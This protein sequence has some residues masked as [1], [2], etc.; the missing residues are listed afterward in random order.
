MKNQQL[1]Q[2]KPL[3]NNTLGSKH[4]M[5]LDNE[6]VVIGKIGATYGIKGWL[7]IVSFT[8]SI[9]NIINYNPWYIEEHKSWQPLKMNEARPH[10]KGII[11][12]I[13][14]FDTPEQARLLTGKQI[15]IKRSQL[16]PL[17]QHEYYWAEL[18]GLTVINQHNET[19]GKIIYL[20]ET[21]SNDVFVVKGDKE[22]AIPYLP[23]VIT[24]I[25]LAEKIM[26]VNWD[27]I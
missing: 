18:E 19:L 24:D 4:S 12:K 17:Q 16:A 7:K 11:A 27:V 5:S 23:E 6:Y 13:S 2:K 22:H 15:A 1:T 10:G 14:G 21:G 25:N 8:E 3:S 20:I 26:R 9:I